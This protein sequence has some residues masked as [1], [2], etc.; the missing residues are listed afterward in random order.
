M[1][2]EAA[3]ASITGVYVGSLRMSV[4]VFNCFTGGLRLEQP[5]PHVPHPRPA[6]TPSCPLTRFVAHRGAH[7]ESRM[8]LPFNLRQPF[9]SDPMNA[10]TYCEEERSQLRKLKE[11]QLARHASVTGPYVCGGLGAHAHARVHSLY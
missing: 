6:R 11:L 10:L 7:A 1:D 9:S 3:P 8:L 4:R 5:H 2:S